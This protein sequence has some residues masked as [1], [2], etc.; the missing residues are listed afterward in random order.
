MEEQEKTVN[1]ESEETSLPEE[2]LMD[3]TFAKERIGFSRPKAIAVIALAATV[4]LA[5]VLLVAFLPRSEGHVVINEAMTSNDEAFVHPEYGS[6]DWVE[7]YNPT[8]AAVDLSG[9]GLTDELK[10]QYKYTFP[11]G[12]V[13]EGGAYLVLYCTGG[14]TATD[15]DPYCTGF[16]LSQE[17]EQLYLLGKNYLELDELTLPM[18][19]TDTAYARTDD[20]R[21]AVTDTVTPGEANRFG[22]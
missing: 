13:L 3:G 19:D 7:L 12:T 5:I 22:D 2:L 9:F 4:V 16:A 6:V 11:E 1:T 10:K 21:F 8:S 15:A 14:T 18:L 17:G 20:G